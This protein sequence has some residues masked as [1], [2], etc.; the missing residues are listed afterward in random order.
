KR[1]EGNSRCYR[2]R[3]DDGACIVPTGRSKCVSCPNECSFK[4]SERSQRQLLR[5]SSAWSMLRTLRLLQSDHKEAAAIEE[6]QDDLARV[7]MVFGGLS[8]NGQIVDK[9]L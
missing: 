8:H 5:L 3:V 9:G 2:C 4:P 6:A 1:F 7:A